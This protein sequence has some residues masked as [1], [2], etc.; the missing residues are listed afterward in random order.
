[1]LIRIVTNRQRE[2]NVASVSRSVAKDVRLFY[3]THRQFNEYE[4][5]SGASAL[6]DTVIGL[7]ARVNNI[8]RPVELPNGGG[9]LT[10]PPDV[11]FGLLVCSLTATFSGMMYSLP[12]GSF[13]V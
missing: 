5:P 2:K 7:F 1:M 12:R 9:R 13:S 11:D 4:A 3:L 6:L 8:R 10:N